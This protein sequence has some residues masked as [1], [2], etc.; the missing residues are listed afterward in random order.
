MNNYVD[1]R[2]EMSNTAHKCLICKDPR[3]NACFL[4]NKSSPQAD[5]N[6]RTM[7]AFSARLR[8]VRHE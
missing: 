7:T 3:C 4:S 6:A 5:S 2:E 1:K 8:S